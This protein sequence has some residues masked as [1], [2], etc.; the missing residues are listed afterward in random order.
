MFDTS[1][2]ACIEATPNH[3]KK[4]TLRYREADAT[5]REAFLQEIATIPDDRIVYVDETGID[6][7]LYRPYARAAMG[8]LVYGKVSGRRYKRTSIVAAQ[9]K[10][11]IL[12]PLQYSG[13]MD[14]ALFL[15]WFT[16]MLL[17]CL[18]PGSVIVMDHARFH[19]KSKL[20][21]VAH[22]M[23]C[24]IMFLP[25]YS[26]DFNL[27]EHFWAWLK[28]RLRKILPA[29]SSLDDAVLDCFNVK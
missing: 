15:F 23:G 11:R 2:P 13:T 9:H 14:S 10:G 19:C 28:V 22:A 18:S 24:H 20:L 29:F 4:K 6:Q 3:T 21:P 17:P 8:E 5:R 1:S 7:H 25:P 26:P 12:A 27:I 16:T